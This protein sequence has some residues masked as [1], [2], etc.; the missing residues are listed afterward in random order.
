M[1]TAHLNSAC[2]SSEMQ[3]IIWYL[4]LNT[5][6]VGEFIDEFEVSGAPP[7]WIKRTLKNAEMDIP[8]DTDPGMRDDTFRASEGRDSK[9]TKPKKKANDVKATKKKP[10]PKAKGKPLTKTPTAK[11]KRAES[12]DRRES[13][14]D[15]QPLLKKQKPQ[16][17]EMT[18]HKENLTPE[19][20]ILRMIAHT[21]KAE[22]TILVP[23]LLGVQARKV[24]VC[25]FSL[26]EV[27]TASLRSIF[28]QEDD[29]V[30][31]D[32]VESTA[33]VKLMASASTPTLK[34]ETP[35]QAQEPP[36]VQPNE[37]HSN[38]SRS[39]NVKPEL[40]HPKKP[41]HPQHTP[42]QQ[43]QQAQQHLLSFQKPQLPQIIFPSA[44]HSEA[45]KVQLMQQEIRNLL[46]AQ[47]QSQGH[48]T[49]RIQLPP[50]SQQQQGQPQ[51]LP[52]SQAQLQL[53]QM[54][55][56]QALQLHQQRVSKPLKQEAAKNPPL[57]LID[58][59]SEPPQQIPLSEMARSM[60]D[61]SSI[62]QPTRTRPPAQS[63]S[64][65]PNAP[66]QQTHL[67]QQ[68]Q[69]VQHVQAIHR[70]P[71]QTPA[72]PHHQ[73]LVQH[74]I[75]PEQQHAQAL[76]QMEHNPEQPTADRAS[77]VAPSTKLLRSRTIT[78]SPNQNQPQPQP[79]PQPQLSQY[80][81]VFRSATTPR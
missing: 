6:P 50:H 28:P 70:T 69:H 44:P 46:Q 10:K 63:Q 71:Q 21:G 65:Q 25:S 4:L 78:S 81:T 8:T 66:P 40:E 57:R 9:Q 31:E 49:Q 14:E 73:R 20:D 62:R 41:L 29:A 53:Q 11:R 12:Q 42:K 26:P 58:A 24:K 2:S 79:Q 75:P 27:Y 23:S 48:L 64:Q 47:S 68:I 16:Q 15:L 7:G 77:V 54:Q 72:G 5:D 61:L 35:E 36:S 43:Q 60:N 37:L 59:V 76:P 34:G 51:V 55:Q 67:Q 80:G 30:S 52:H 1:S 74:Q 19:E 13:I 32:A 56:M 22:K 39:Q 45:Q 38:S 33:T 18:E 17:T 3:Q